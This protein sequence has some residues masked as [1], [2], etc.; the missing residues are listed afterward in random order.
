MEGESSQ[1]SAG[2]GVLDVCR[3]CITGCTGAVGPVCS[4]AGHSVLVKPCV[5]LEPLSINFAYSEHSLLHS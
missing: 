1:L 3:K 2:T 5:H 4:S